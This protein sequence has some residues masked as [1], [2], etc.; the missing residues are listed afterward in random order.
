MI[1]IVGD[2][3]RI[4]NGAVEGGDELQ[5]GRTAFVRRYFPVQCIVKTGCSV[6]EKI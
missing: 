3:E 6:I 5:Y 4:R 1:G 2:P